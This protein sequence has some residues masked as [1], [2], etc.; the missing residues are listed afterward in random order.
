M[1]SITSPIGKQHAADLLLVAS[2]VAVLTTVHVLVPSSLQDQLAL[3]PADPQWYTL[4]TAAYTHASFDHLQGNLIGY[5]LAVGYV[6]WLC[7][8]LERRQWF[9]QTTLGLLIITPFVVNSANVLLYGTYL[10]EIGGVARGFSGVVAAFVGFLLISFTAAIREAHTTQLAQVVGVGLILILLLLIDTVYA[11]TLRP[12]V[13]GLVVFGICIQA[14]PIL[15]HRDWDILV[16]TRSREQLLFQ[17]AGSSL[18]VVVLAILT[19]QM[20]PAE[21]VVGNS[22]VNIFAHGIGFT[23]GIAVSAV[24]LSYNR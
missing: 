4:L 23:V 15:Y 3:R 1:R 13:A 24:L 22:F 17:I 18:I 14:V 20:F 8:Y 11:R 2:I 21:V 6:Y 10:P 16:Q 9:W 5:L 12:I 19:L 7:L